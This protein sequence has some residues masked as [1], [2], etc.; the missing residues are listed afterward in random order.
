MKF[1]GNYFSSSP[2]LRS[3]YIKMPHFGPQI[4]HF[5]Y[6]TFVG[7]SKCIYLGSTCYPAWFHRNEENCLSWYCIKKTKIKTFVNQ[8][9]YLWGFTFS[10]MCKFLYVYFFDCSKLAVYTTRNETIFLLYWIGS[11]HKFSNFG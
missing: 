7:K 1:K 5:P 4:T 10:G 6:L 8:Y 9:I 11:S 2:N 3:R